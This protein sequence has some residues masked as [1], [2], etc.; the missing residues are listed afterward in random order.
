[1][2][3]AFSLESRSA[4]LSLSASDGTD[5]TTPVA[6]VGVAGAT[7]IGRRSAVTRPPSHRITARSIAFLGSRTF[8][9]SS[10]GAFINKSTVDTDL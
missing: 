6:T 1:V 7:V 8:S 10:N 4:T 2:L 9:Y 3:T 5:V